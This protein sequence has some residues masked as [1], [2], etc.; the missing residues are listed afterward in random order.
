MSLILAFLAT[1]PV[2]R[3]FYRYKDDWLSCSF[4]FRGTALAIVFVARRGG[5]GSAL[6][7]L[8]NPLAPNRV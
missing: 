1:K 4:P 8:V 5:E 7:S 6:I 3:V 2:P